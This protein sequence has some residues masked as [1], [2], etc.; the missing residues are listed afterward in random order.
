MGSSQRAR[1][2]LILTAPLLDVELVNE[3]PTKTAV[4]TLRD[5]DDVGPLRREREAWFY[6]YEKFR[7]SIEYRTA[8]VFG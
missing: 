4:D 1:A 2:E 3:K 5:L 7:L 8:V 6:F